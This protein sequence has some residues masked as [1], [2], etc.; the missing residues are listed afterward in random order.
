MTHSR[1]LALPDEEATR[2]LGRAL[3]GRA[4]TGDVILL[5]GSL[6]TGKTTLARAFIQA[7]AGAD[8][9]VP[10]PTFTLVQAYDTPRGTVWHFDLYRLKRSDEVVELGFDDAVA[11]GIAVVEWPDR[12]GPLTPRRHL[13]VALAAGEG[14]DSRIATL[15]PHGQWDTRIGDL[16]P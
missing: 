5:A 6:G 3:A 7:L 12:L 14:A 9:D 11:D 2:R 15:T 10:S 1:I 13:L 4:R 8:E 16:T